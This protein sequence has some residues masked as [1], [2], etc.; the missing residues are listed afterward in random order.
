MFQGEDVKCFAR[1]RE[2]DYGLCFR[3]QT[4][5]QFG[6]SWRLLANFI[7]LNPGSALPIDRTPKNEYLQSKNLPFYIDGDGEYYSFYIDR[8][9]NDLL[10][11]YSSKYGGGVIKIYNLFNLK[12]Q[13]SGSAIEQYKQH[14]SSRYI[15]TEPKDIKY[16][17]APVVV[18][19]GGN[20]HADLGLKEELKKYI[21]LADPS[22]LYSLVKIGDKEFT[23]KKAHPN[24]SGLIDS[25][26]PS[27]TFKY[28]N[29]TKFI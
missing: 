21:S 9:M 11:L 28:G 20:V 24:D 2:Q 23:V 10:K 5:L 4:I 16:C 27:Y 3:D 26:H 8:L 13:D 17:D 15:H 22:S 18:A 7:L 12:N 19:V 6:G 1:W 14:K 29:I 25:Y